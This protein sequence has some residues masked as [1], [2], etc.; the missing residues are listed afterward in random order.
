MRTFEEIASRVN[1]S[2]FFRKFD[3]NKA[4]TQIQLSE[5]S[6]LLTT[7]ATPWGRYCWNRMA[8]GLSSAPEVFHSV[9]EDIVGGI[10]GVKVSADDVLQ[11][12]SSIEE[13]NEITRKVPYH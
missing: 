1:G 10:K 7:F 2:R 13:L 8:Y 5:R 3:N 4:F 11:H 6:Q 9:M 12:A